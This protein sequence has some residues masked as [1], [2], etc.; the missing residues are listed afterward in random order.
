MSCVRSHFDVLTLISWRKKKIRGTKSQNIKIFVIAL[1][2]IWILIPEI[3]LY[4]IFSHTGSAV[5]QLCF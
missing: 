4:F 5:C 3:S 2:I 1:L